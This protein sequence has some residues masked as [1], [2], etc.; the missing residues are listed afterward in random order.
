[1]PRI[2]ALAFLC[3]GMITSAY[4]EPWPAVLP[5]TK[6][7]LIDFSSEW[8]SIDLPIAGISGKTEYLFWCRGGSTENLDAYEEKTGMSFVG[9]FLCRL[10]EGATPQDISLLQE[11]GAA[12]WYSRGLFSE[13]SVTGACAAYPEYG[14]RRTFALRNMRLTL[15]LHDV[16][17][18]SN[19]GFS[20]FKLLVTVRPDK[21][22][23]GS[24]AQRPRYLSPKWGDCSKVRRGIEPR[25]CR[26]W[27]N[28]G[29]S[30]EH[31][32]KIGS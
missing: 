27:K 9:S 26:D 10:N 30:W 7:Y 31:C 21:K 3:V 13:P 8:V 18:R 23:T 1:M 32:E 29:G 19:G 24:V 12:V 28:K 22:A 15:E 6:E 2:L 20:R 14:A 4:A 11:D 25:M 16:Q 5:L 17:L